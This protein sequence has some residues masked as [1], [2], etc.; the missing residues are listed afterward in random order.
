M[1]ALSGISKLSNGG[2][3]KKCGVRTVRTGPHKKKV[4]EER[5]LL[6]FT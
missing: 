1:I 5:S 4:H 3:E 6:T 2:G